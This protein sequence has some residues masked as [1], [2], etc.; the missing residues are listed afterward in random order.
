MLPLPGSFL[1]R[2]SQKCITYYIKFN[3]KV[4]DPKDYLHNQLIRQVVRDAQNEAWSEVI[5]DPKVQVIIAEQ[6]EQKKKQQQ[7]RRD[8]QKLAIDEAKKDVDKILNMQNK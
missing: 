5:K 7:V 8:G 6:L 1:L 2:V 4:I 3:I